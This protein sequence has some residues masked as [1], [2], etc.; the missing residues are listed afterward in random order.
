M[1]KLFI[2]ECAVYFRILCSVAHYYMLI[3]I[4]LFQLKMKC[5]FHSGFYM[6][7]FSAQ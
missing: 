7:K 1:Y 5:I 4:R 2:K 3:S 6:L